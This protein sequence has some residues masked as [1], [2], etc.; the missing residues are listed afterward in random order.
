[1]A[2]MLTIVMDTLTNAAALPAGP[3]TPEAT[4]AEAGVDSMAVAVLAMVLEEDHGLVIPES[5]IT[6]LSS[7]STLTELAAFLEHYQVTTA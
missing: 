5:D 3:V 2:D 6:G 1:M 7:T 4:L